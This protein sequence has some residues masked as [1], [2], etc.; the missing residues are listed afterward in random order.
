MSDTT[1]ELNRVLLDITSLERRSSLITSRI[2]NGIVRLPTMITTNEIIYVSSITLYYDLSNLVHDDI[3]TVIIGRS[4][5]IE[6]PFRSTVDD[7]IAIP[8]VTTL[9]VNIV[10]N[11]FIL[12]K[13]DL[14]RLFPSLT[15]WV[16]STACFFE[17]YM[18]A[19]VRIVKQV[20]CRRLVIL[21]NEAELIDNDFM[22][23]LALGLIDNKYTK[24]LALINT[25]PNRIAMVRVG[26]AVF[27]GI[28]IRLRG[29]YLV[30]MKKCQGL[31][32][33]SQL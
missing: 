32:N 27:N 17:Y 3:K 23:N 7:T 6:L 2:D 24:E 25:K 30:G 28:S 20:A 4:F 13:L 16:I 26:G 18:N 11:Q 22:I 21:F 14:N 19:L 5:E 29:A 9:S 12:D 8:N 1:D 15:T 33:V 10:G 31:G